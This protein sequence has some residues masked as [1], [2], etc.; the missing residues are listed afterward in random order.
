MNALKIIKYS[1]LAILL[2]VVGLFLH[3]NLPRTYVV[4]ITG[5][6]VKRMDMKKPQ[7]GEVTRDIRYLNTVTRDGKIRVFRTFRL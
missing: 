2:A 1:L 5:T 4:Q 3:Y 6:D 7:Q